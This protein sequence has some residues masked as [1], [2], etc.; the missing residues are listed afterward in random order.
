LASNNPNPKARTC[1]D[2]DITAAGHALSLVAGAPAG[3]VGEYRQHLGYATGSAAANRY[4]FYLL[5]LL[6]PQGSLA[7]VAQLFGL[8]TF[9][10]S[11]TGLVIGSVIYSLPFVVQPLVNGFAAIPHNLFEVAATLGATPLQRFTRIALPLAKPGFVVAF[12]LGFA[13]TLG[14]FGVVLMIGGN[15]PG[16]TRVVSIAIYEQVESLQWGAAHQMS[17]LMLLFA[18]VVILITH[19][20]QK[21]SALG[22]SLPVRSSKAELSKSKHR[23]SQPSKADYWRDAEAEKTDQ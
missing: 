5:L 11:F 9:A 22:L 1:I 10:F 7:N 18:F 13:H 14:E 15:I 3:V 12:V 20:L 21:Y 2:I 16:E 17:L 6:S 8:T 19:R 4:W 23:K